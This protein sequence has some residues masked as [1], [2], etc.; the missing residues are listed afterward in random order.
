[1]I[2]SGYI[3]NHPDHGLPRKT[4]AESNYFIRLVSGKPVALE[5][6][7]NGEF[8]RLMVG[9]KFSVGDLVWVDG[10][11]QGQRLQIA[12]D[13]LQA[14]LRGALTIKDVSR[15]RKAGIREAKRAGASAKLLSK[16]YNLPEKVIKE[17]LRGG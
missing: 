16:T 17:V 12:I 1:M 11:P 8:N 13:E 7:V 2:R 10:D 5:K 3:A 15:S 14:R 6:W 4:P 9:E